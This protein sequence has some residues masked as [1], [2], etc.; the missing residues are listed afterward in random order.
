MSKEGRNFP[1]TSAPTF[2]VTRQLSNEAVLKS[3]AA[4][5]PNQRFNARNLGQQKVTVVAD[6]CL[7]WEHSCFCNDCEGWWIFYAW[8]LRKKKSRQELRCKNQLTLSEHFDGAND[9]ERENCCHFLFHVKSNLKKTKLLLLLA[10][11]SFLWSWFCQKVEN[12]N[13]SCVHPAGVQCAAQPPGCSASRVFNIVVK[14]CVHKCLAHLYLQEKRR[15]SDSVHEIYGIN[16]NYNPCHGT[17]KSGI[18]DLYLCLVESWKSPSP[19][20][21]PCKKERRGG[22]YDET[23]IFFPRMNRKKNTV[24]SFFFVQGTFVWHAVLPA[25]EYILSK[26]TTCKGD[27]FRKRSGIKALVFKE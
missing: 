23:L 24:P 13:I 4:V 3:P 25:P 21:M 7:K 9:L 16:L 12:C 19:F 17:D 8:N 5:Q 6:N 2:C 14:V 15:M 1:C 26:D 22:W 18:P 27:A 11:A 10:M 20:P